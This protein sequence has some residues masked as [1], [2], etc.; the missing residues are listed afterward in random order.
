MN[1]PDI[2]YK[3]TLFVL[4]T[5]LLLNFINLVIFCLNYPKVIFFLVIINEFSSA[6]YVLNSYKIAYRFPFY[7]EVKIVF[8][9]WLL[10]PATK[11]SSILYM[12]FV[13]PQLTKREP[14]SGFCYF[15]CY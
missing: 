12:Q 1:N 3:S 10:S 11:G 6:G 13:H 15:G 7:Y 8:V 9:L 2:S 14:V 5:L 4:F